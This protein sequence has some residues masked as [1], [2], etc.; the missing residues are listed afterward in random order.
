M[1][2]WLGQWRLADILQAVGNSLVQGGMPGRLLA[3]C[4]TSRRSSMEL[5]AVA[6]D[7]EGYDLLPAC[8]R[9]ENQ[10][11]CHWASAGR[12][13]DLWGLPQVGLIFNLHYN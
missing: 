9:R 11:S 13:L 6:R 4:C 8:A 7:V 5:A 3:G 12:N 2:R 10:Y 1:R